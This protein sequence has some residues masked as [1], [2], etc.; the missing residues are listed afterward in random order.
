M[1]SGSRG[2]W[3][4]SAKVSSAPCLTLALVLSGCSEPARWTKDTDRYPLTGA[5]DGLVSVDSAKW[6]EY[7]ATLEN[8]NHLGAFFLRLALSLRPSPE[9]LQTRNARRR[10]YTRL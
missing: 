9:R 5:N 1:L 10:K 4:T 8:V 3:S 2:E 7:R 6:G